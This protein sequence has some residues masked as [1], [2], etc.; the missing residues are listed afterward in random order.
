MG[1]QMAVQS[2]AWSMTPQSLDEAM[3]YADMIANSDIVPADYK[4]KPGNVLI[5]MQ[6]GQ[7]LGLQTMQALQNIAVINGR[8]SV[9]GD[10]LMA[11]VKAHPSCEYITENFDEQAM[12]ATCTVKRRG[13]PEQTRAF[14]KA[15]A[16]KASL[17]NKSG[18]WQTYPK[19]MLQMRARGFA[20]RDVFP[21]ALRGISLAEEARDT[22]P[23][24]VTPTQPTGQPVEQSAAE[25]PPA[26]PHYSDERLEENLDKWKQAIDS[27]KRSADD[28]IGMVESQYTLSDA[29]K[30]R[31]RELENGE[32]A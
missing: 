9:W 11:I 4:G 3:K 17:W 10:S 25:E 32:T 1:E 18:P 13:N 30:Q 31:I 28:L 19:R 22:P 15:D 29:Q 6:M 24:D 21:D 2:G 26:L 14:G 23:R 12:V 16:D 7:E 8:P 20:L 27:G 5:A